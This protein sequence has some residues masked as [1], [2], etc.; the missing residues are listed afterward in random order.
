MRH[1]TLRTW[2]NR[3]GRSS[4]TGP[5]RLKLLKR[6]RRQLYVEPLEYRRLP[7]SVTN[8]ADAGSGSLRDA[9]ATTPS[10]GTVDFQPGLSGT[11]TLTSATLTIGKDLTIMGPGPDVITGGN[12]VT[13]SGN[14]SLQ[15]IKIA[16]GAN[17]TIIS[18]TIANGMAPQGSF[19]GGIDNQGT[20]TVSAST[21][22]GNSAGHGKGGA[23]YNAGSLTV[24]FTTLSGNG[25]AGNG[26]GIS[27][28]GTLTVNNSSI[29]GN[30]ASQGLGSGI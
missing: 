18:L 5:R 27:N 23:I 30:T 20:L 9:I 2:L 3:I 29:S 21:L 28:D 14:K 6:K 12:L 15:V 1:V 4:R 10:G 16:P 11:I 19:G 17:V 24:S 7:S 22:S 13:V 26:G 25:V 8:L